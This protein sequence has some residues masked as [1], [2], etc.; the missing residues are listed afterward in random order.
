MTITR[1][2]NDFTL[3]PRLLSQIDNTTID[4]SS[5]NLFVK[6]VEY[7]RDIRVDYSTYPAKKI[8]KT[9]VPAREQGTMVGFCQCE[10]GFL[11]SQMT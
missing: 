5:G 3:L 1:E 7:H 9:K 11:L 8:P 6:M 10:S 2:M 4:I